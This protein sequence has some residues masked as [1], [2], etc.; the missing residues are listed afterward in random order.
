MLQLC[1]VDID[2][3]LHHTIMRYDE[4]SLILSRVEK[5]KELDLSKLLGGTSSSKE[6]VEEISVIYDRKTQETHADVTTTA[7]S[8]SDGGH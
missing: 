4:D 7:E 6:S 5:L 2:R 1:A 8:S 3:N